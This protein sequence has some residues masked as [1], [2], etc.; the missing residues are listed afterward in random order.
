M[1]QKLCSNCKSPVAGHSGASGRHCDW[2]R[3]A[4]YDSENSDNL[5]DLMEDEAKSHENQDILS[6]I[7]KLTAAVEGL[8]SREIKR[9]NTESPVIPPRGGVHI[10]S[11]SGDSASG[12][13][14][15]REPLQQPPG[16]IITQQTPVVVTTQTLRRD[17]DLCY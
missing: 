8:I 6:K 3:H 15:G 13:T 5:E 17:R 10:A 1:S 4:D 11:T 16:V 9:S 14:S 7:D 12:G 2:P